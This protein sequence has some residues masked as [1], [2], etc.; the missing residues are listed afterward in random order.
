MMYSRDYRHRAWKTLANGKFGKVFIIALVLSFITSAVFTIIATAY[1]NSTDV[2][3][4]F[5]DALTALTNVDANNQAAF[6]AAFDEYTSALIAFSFGP[7]RMIFYLIIYAG[8]ALSM[9]AALAN[10]WIYLETSREKSVTVGGFAAKLKFALSSFW[11]SL[12]IFVRVFLWS[13]LFIIP[14]IVKA[15]SYYMA[16]FVKLDNPEMSAGKCIKE[17][18][19]MMYGHRA[20]LFILMLSFIGWWLLAGITA[21]IISAVLGLFVP[22]WEY[23]SPAFMLIFTVPV[24]VYMMTAVAVFYRDLKGEDPFGKL[25]PTPGQVN[26]AEGL[27][28]VFDGIPNNNNNDPFAGF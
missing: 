14:G 15:L 6:N 13:L 10:Q 7:E 12:N 3:E 26:F 23:I 4:R 17:S 24:T 8:F 2:A 16:F 21:G 1:F 18:S 25:V 22:A 9:F 19:R 20:R 5:N 28:D 27:G 11:L